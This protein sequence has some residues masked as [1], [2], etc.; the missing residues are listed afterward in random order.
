MRLRAAI[1]VLFATLQASGWAA[2]KDLTLRIGYQKYGT[3]VFEKARGTL[4]K[5]LAPL[6]VSVTWTEFLGGPALLEA[7]GADSI[8]FGIA[9]DAP[10]D[11]R[12]GGRRAARLCRRRARQPAWRG[13]H[14]AGMLSRSTASP[15]LRGKRSR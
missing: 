10:A 14:R 9:G 12:P 8:D 6:H 7:M 5:K 15:I 2:A 3:L 11:L 1:L 13:G 4:E